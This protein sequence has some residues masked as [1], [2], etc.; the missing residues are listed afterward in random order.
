M[1]AFFC[2]AAESHMGVPF[3][4]YGSVFFCMAGRFS[5]TGVP[6]FCMAA[7]FSVWQRRATRVCLFCLAAF[8][9]VWLVA[10]ATQVCLLSVWQ[11]IFLY[12]SREPHGLF[13]YGQT[14]EGIIFFSVLC[15]ICVR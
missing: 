12:G 11:R 5:H 4:L 14:I 8:F 13:L 15:Q 7:Y 9:F 2:M 1:A 3:F 10:L 6:F